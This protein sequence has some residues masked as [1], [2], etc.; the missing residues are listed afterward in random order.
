MGL[1]LCLI[2]RKGKPLTSYR[3]ILGKLIFFILHL[4]LMCITSHIN[5]MIIP[6]Q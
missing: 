6:K 3:D 5:I 4:S 2:W 1:F